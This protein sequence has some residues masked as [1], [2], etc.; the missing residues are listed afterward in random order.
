ML[1]SNVCFLKF[2]ILQTCQAEAIS[3][4]IKTMRMRMKMDLEHFT[5]VLKTKNEAISPVFDN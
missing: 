5:S 3:F 4:L 1:F 2:S